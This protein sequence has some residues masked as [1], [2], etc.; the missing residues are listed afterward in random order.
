[1]TTKRK[2]P[3]RGLQ[4]HTQ[5]N[6]PNP[7]PILGGYTPQHVSQQP[8]CWGV[9]QQDHYQARAPFNPALNMGNYGTPYVSQPQYTAPAPLFNRVYNVPQQ[10]NYAQP[11]NIT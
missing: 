7:N 3:K 2:I 10:P 1:M 4:P 9:P 6:I 5:R 11:G 8:N